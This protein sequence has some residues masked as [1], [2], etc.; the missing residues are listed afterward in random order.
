MS[1][2]DIIKKY[3]QAAKKTHPDE[4]IMPVLWIIMKPSIIW[5]R[6]P[7]DER[8]I[9]DNQSSDRLSLNIFEA[10]SILQSKPKS[11]YGFGH[12]LLR[13]KDWSIF[14]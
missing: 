10:M 1:R 12:S 14:I 11:D 9:A 2:N 4:R 8:Q 5:I 6:Q 7:A 13:M 3:R